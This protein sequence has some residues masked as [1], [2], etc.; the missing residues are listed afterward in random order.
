MTL[1]SLGLTYTKTLVSLYQKTSQNLTLKVVSNTLQIF[2]L[3]LSKCRSKLIHRFGTDTHAESM[4]EE[5][6]CRKIYGESKRGTN[7]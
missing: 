1:T 3:K 6:N 4:K 2:I 5:G 7:K